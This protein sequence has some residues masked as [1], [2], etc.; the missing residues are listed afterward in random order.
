[1]A[2]PPRSE[3]DRAALWAGLAAGEVDTV[4]TDHCPFFYATQKTW[5]LG[6]FSR[7]PG[8]IPGVETRVALL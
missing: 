6:D 2:P 5:G 4:A 8:G 7:I 3:V 1:M